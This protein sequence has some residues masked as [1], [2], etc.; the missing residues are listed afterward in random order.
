MK[1]VNDKELRIMFMSLI[2]KLQSVSSVFL[3][4][5]EL[6]KDEYEELVEQIREFKDDAYDILIKAHDCIK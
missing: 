6:D 3:H 5:K 1:A 2:D 4:E